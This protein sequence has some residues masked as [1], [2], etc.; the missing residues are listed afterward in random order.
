MDPILALLD[1]L[2]SLITT[3]AIAGFIVLNLGF[4]ALVALRR[5]RAIVNRW[6]KPL[7]VADTVLLLVA[8]GA[9]AASWALRTSVRAVAIAMPDLPGI[10]APS[11]TKV[12]VEVSDPMEGRAYPLP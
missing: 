11:D 1:S 7:V 3:V 12:T 8:G 10:G 5:D 4:I 6:T 9:P 2:G